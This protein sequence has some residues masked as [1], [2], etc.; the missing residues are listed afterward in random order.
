MRYHRE[1]TGSANPI[2]FRFIPSRDRQ[3]RATTYRRDVGAV[4]SQRLNSAADSR[5]PFNNRFGIRQR[6]V[7]HR[8]PK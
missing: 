1:A 4:N 6:L 5:Q 2:K 3:D 8:L 7:V